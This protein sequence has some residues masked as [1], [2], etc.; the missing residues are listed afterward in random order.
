[1]D[2]WL[3]AEI[4]RR[5]GSIGR[6]SV[7]GQGKRRFGFNAVNVW[8]RR[9]GRSHWSLGIF[10][11]LSVPLF[12]LPLHNRSRHCP[13]IAQLISSPPIPIGTSNSHLEPKT[14]CRT[15][16]ACMAERFD[17]LWGNFVSPLFVC[18]ITAMPGLEVLRI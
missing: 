11:Q 10:L 7:R 13:G 6:L 16:P 4:R 8:M 18:C 17:V 14:L 1:M 15:T 9:Y 12:P 3:A 2:R 5:F